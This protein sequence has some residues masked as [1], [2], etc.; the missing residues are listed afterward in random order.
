MANAGGRPNKYETHIKPRLAEVE[1]LSQFMTEEEMAKYFGVHASSWYSYKSK[2]S[3]FFEAI[4]KG[5]KS[6]VQ[7][8]KQSLVDKAKG[9]KYTEKK[10]VREKNE[11]GD[12][13]ITREEEYI[14]YSPP[15]VAAL[16]LLL[17]NYDKENWAN[18]PA[19]IALRKKELEL[20]ER[21]I[22]A[23]EW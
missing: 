4:K 7:D 12:L 8:L 22:E 19:V 15:D 5:K 16:N 13:V 9:F 11:V 10:I 1:K 6:L 20:R 3:E 23:G 2:Y 18:D 14:K 21:Q 17:K